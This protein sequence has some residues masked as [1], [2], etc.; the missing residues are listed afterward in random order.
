MTRFAHRAILVLGAL[1]SGVL[2]APTLTPPK[3]H[4][5][6]LGQALQSSN[7]P[8]GG[9]PSGPAGDD[10]LKVRDDGGGM[11]LAVR[12]DEES[13]A[14]ELVFRPGGEPKRLYEE[15]LNK[16]NQISNK[17]NAIR[18]SLQEQAHT[19]CSS[20]LSIWHSFITGLGALRRPDNT[21]ELWQEIADRY[22]SLSKEIESLHGFQDQNP[23][24]RQLHE[25]VMKS[26]EAA[27]GQAQSE[28]DRG[29][30]LMWY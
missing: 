12:G 15:E 8:I 11:T 16:I 5:T 14:L 20:I 24:Y 22:R 25:L 10:V 26:V 29:K 18:E 28:R 1:S 13:R 4:S 6:E 17:Y 2:A 3:S 23:L 27:E 7:V 9:L 19:Q 30:L 21:A